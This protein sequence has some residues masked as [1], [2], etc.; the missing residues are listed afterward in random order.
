MNEIEIVEGTDWNYHTAKDGGSEALCGEQVM[1]CGTERWKDQSR[2]VRDSYYGEEC[3]SKL[4]HR[5]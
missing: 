5:V 4:A 2:N 3:G 1:P